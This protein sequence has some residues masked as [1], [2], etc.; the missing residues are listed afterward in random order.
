M[1]TSEVQRT[2]VK[3]PPELWTELSDPE[4]LARHLAELGH[5]AEKPVTLEQ[6]APGVGDKLGYLY[7]FGDNWEHDI[8]V[9]KLLDRQAVTYPRCIGGRRAAPPC[10]TGM[11][12][13]APS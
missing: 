10:T 7:D 3:S 6:V 12:R 2:L 9:E 1:I 4:S 11:S 5:R 13:T 8:L